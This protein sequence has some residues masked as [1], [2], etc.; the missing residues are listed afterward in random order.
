MKPIFVC[1]L[2]IN[3]TDF[4]DMDTVRF[5]LKEELSEDYH[6]LVLSDNTEE[7]KFELYNSELEDKDF[8]DL[9][10]KLNL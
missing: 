4:E 8:E 2:P 10:L 3:N 7:V 1:R 6:V 9:K 5:H